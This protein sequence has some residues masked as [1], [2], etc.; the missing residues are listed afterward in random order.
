MLQKY[1]YSPDYANNSSK[2][3]RLG[4]Y[5]QNSKNYKDLKV[6]KLRECAN[7]QRSATKETLATEG[8][9]EIDQI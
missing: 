3:R 6:Q 7:A 4:R 1:K 2:K 8:T 5:A 9:Q